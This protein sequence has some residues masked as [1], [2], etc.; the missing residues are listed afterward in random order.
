MRPCRCGSTD[1]A[2]GEWDER[3][4]RC[5]S[6]GTAFTQP[7]P[8][9]EKAKRPAAHR[10]LAKR[11]GRGFCEYCLRLEKDLPAGQVLEGHHV[12]QYEDGGTDERENVH[13]ICT[14]CH[15][16]THQKRTY[17]GHYHSRSEEDAA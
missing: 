14:W 12:V 1:L 3:A 7:K 10:A 5:R 13:V 8:K 6:C 17:L 15:V 4:V 16:D 11:F 9:N 2:P